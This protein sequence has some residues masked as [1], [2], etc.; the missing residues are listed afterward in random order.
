MGEF[1]SYSEWGEEAKRRAET[2]YNRPV[3][4][5]ID[6]FVVNLGASSDRIDTESG[7]RLKHKLKAKVEENEE[8]VNNGGGIWT[9]NGGMDLY[10][11]KA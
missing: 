6:Y 11:L 7:G 4:L 9:N 2:I 8:S 1:S 5:V 10:D 3:S